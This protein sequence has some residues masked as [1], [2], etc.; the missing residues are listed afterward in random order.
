VCKERGNLYTFRSPCTYQH[1]FFFFLFLFCY[2]LHI[3]VVCILY[4]VFYRIL[5]VLQE[6]FDMEKNIELLKKA[7]QDKEQPMQV[8]HTRLET[9]VH[10]PNVELCRDPVQHRYI[11]HLF[12]VFLYY[13]IDQMYCIVKQMKA[14]LS[15]SH[16]DN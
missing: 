15:S 1:S 8:A 7:I 16:R 4:T 13:L 14:V 10:R 12:S 2:T 5:Q 9:R 6:I 11:H 3:F